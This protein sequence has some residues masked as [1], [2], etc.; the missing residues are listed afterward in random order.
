MRVD[1]DEI[2][3][4]DDGISGLEQEII[5]VQGKI[6]KVEADVDEVMAELAATGMSKVSIS[7]DPAVVQLRDK[8]KQLR[9]EKKQL[10][11]KEKQLRDEKKLLLEKQ[12]RLEGG[13]GAKAVRARCAPGPRSPVVPPARLRR[14][15]TAHAARNV[16]SRTLRLPFSRPAHALCPCH[17]PRAP[18]L[19]ACLVCCARRVHL[20]DHHL[21]H[22]HLLR[23]ACNPSA[24]AGIVM[25][26]FGS[27]VHQVRALSC[28]HASVRTFPYS[29]CPDT[30][31]AGIT[32]VCRARTVPNGSLALLHSPRAPTPAAPSCC[33]V[34][35]VI[36][37]RMTLRK[38]LLASAA[39]ALSQ[40]DARVWC[41]L[42]T[43]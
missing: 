2:S 3:R 11:D 1:A 37:V 38:N 43:R 8:E 19:A 5:R 41:R 10:R 13:A 15:A 17:T 29:S 30:P 28:A 12:A 27:A 4:P 40:T 21:S 42:R 14:R 31:M 6:E 25:S 9:D 18:L 22:R 39:L 34:R 16:A 35:M 33:S 24:P 36:G 32:A 20:H 26:S 7:K 23:R